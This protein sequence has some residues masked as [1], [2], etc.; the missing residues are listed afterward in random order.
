MDKGKITNV[1]GDAT[2]PQ[3]TAPE[4][5]VVITHCCNNENKW[6][7][8]FVLA[9][10]KKWK[11]PKQT[12]RN[13]CEGNR[14]FPNKA[15]LNPILGKVCYAKIN[16]H[17]VVANMIGQDGTVT[18]DNPKPVRYRALANC[19]AEVVGYIDM[20]Q[21][22]TDNPVVIHTPKFGSDL[23]GGDF[24]FILELIREIWVDVGID[25]VIYEFEPDPEKWGPIEDDFFDEK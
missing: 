8:G 23:A 3:L 17:L 16:E 2:D 10:N 18:E 14:P 21:S 25:V 11:E 22:Q 20:I 15:A 13:F 7:R 1:R 4:E 12:Y 6:G 5:I 9:L 19:M 24:R